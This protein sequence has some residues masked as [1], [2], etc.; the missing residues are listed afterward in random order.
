MEEYLTALIIQA[1]DLKNVLEK[2][3]GELNKYNF[4]IPT[5]K[6]I[7]ESLIKYAKEENTPDIKKFTKTLAKELT[8]IFDTCYLLPLPKFES[9]EK[10]SKEIK[11]V[12]KELTEVY[13]RERIKEIKDLIK[14]KEGKSD[15]EEMGVL[16]KEFLELL[17]FLPR[18]AKP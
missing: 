1:E 8:N 17:S 14:G 11:K 16:K 10:Y 13:A 2:D 4:F 3:L 9:K 12:I 7:V 6:K 5:N 18:S 15:E